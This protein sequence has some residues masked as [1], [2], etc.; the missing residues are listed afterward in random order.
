[1]ENMNYETKPATQEKTIIKKSSVVLG[2]LI[3]QEPVA[4]EGYI[5]G[6][7][8][9]ISAVALKGIVNGDVEA[10][11]FISSGSSASVLGD[12]TCEEQLYIKDNA[13]VLGNLKAKGVIDVQGAVKGNIETQENVIIRTGSIVLGNITGREITIEPQAKVQGKLIM[14]TDENNADLYNT[15]DKIKTTILAD[16]RY[17][18]VQEIEKKDG[19]SIEQKNG[20]NGKHKH[21]G[22]VVVDAQVREI[23]EAIDETNAESHA[24]SAFG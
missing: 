20:K 14:N 18:N 11:V 19:K 4:V 12:V 7:L 10:K 15:F 21:H 5:S 9:T 6:S 3:T 22:E 1:M 17:V 13:S 8:K 24:E 23:E 2:D 16:I